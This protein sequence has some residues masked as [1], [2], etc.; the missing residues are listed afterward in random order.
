MKPRSTS[1]YV[2]LP[3]R[4]TVVFTLARLLQRLE[5]SIDPVDPRQYRT[6]AQRLAEELALVDGDESLAAILQAHPS[7]GEL[8][9]NLHYEHAGLCRAPLELAASAESEALALLERLG[10]RDAAGRPA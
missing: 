7:A 1:P 9:E 5:L 6:V 10:R 2:R 3:A 8:Y 4:L